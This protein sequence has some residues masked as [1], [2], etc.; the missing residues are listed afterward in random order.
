MSVSYSSAAEEGLSIRDGEEELW[1]HRWKV[2]S[3]LLLDC[4][5]YPTKKQVNAVKN[6][7]KLCSRHGLHSAN[8]GECDVLSGKVS[9]T[10]PMENK[11][12]DE[13]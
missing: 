7:S 11:T 3:E 6:V 1:F 10:V 13:K 12:G 2:D 9:A 8:D 5:E 4:G